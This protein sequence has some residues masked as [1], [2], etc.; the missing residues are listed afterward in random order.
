MLYD[1]NNMIEAEVNQFI[2]EDDDLARKLE[3]RRSPSPSNHKLHRIEDECIQT[4]KASA[5]NESFGQSHKSSTMH[6]RSYRRD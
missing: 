4:Y 5:P 6:E 1:Q 2:A 3:N